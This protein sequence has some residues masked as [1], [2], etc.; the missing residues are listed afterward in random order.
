MKNEIIEKY[1][2][3]LIIYEITPSKDFTRYPTLI[4]TS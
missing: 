1:N 3:E 2:S 4:T